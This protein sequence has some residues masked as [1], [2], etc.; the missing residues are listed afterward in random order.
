M[1]FVKLLGWKNYPT[2]ACMI[3]SSLKAKH[4]RF[5]F[6][7]KDESEATSKPINVLLNCH[8]WFTLGQRLITD[9]KKKQHHLHIKQRYFSKKDFW[10]LMVCVKCDL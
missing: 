9:E 8:Y 10:Y 6:F 5:Q 7:V 2:S 1:F 3:D 4:L